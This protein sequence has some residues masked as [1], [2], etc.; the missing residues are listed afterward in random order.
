MPVLFP[1]GAIV[2]ISQVGATGTIYA[3]SWVVEAPVHDEL[4]IMLGPPHITSETSRDAVQAA[5]DA[6]ASHGGYA[7][8]PRGQAGHERR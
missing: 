1:G 3:R 7:E 6:V 8:W 4:V 2:T 5:S